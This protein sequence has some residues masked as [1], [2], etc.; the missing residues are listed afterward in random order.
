MLGKVA[1]KLRFLGFDTLY[2]ANMDDN[3][4][5]EMNFDKQRIIL[6]SDR[7]L[8]TRSLKLYIPCLLINRENDLENLIIIMKESDIRHIFLVPNEYTRCTICNGLLDI[9][10][11]S[12]SMKIYALPKNVLE[13]NETFFNCVNC[14][15]LYWN[16]THVKEINKL[17]HEINKKIKDKK[18]I[19]I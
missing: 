2:F 10:T 12:S 14:K 5:L 3:K 8:Y 7:Q 13:S 4:I 19:I 18:N 11:K 16:G 6:T 17:I 1:K 9:I 15:K